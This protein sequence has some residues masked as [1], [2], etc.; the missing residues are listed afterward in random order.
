MM[1]NIIRGL[2]VAKTLALLF[3]LFA[4]DLYASDTEVT[5][6]SNYLE[7]QEEDKY[8]VAKG[9][10]VV[11]WEGKTLKAQ[12]VEMDAGK[13]YMIAKGSACLDDGGSVLQGEVIAYDLKKKIGDISKVHGAA[14]EWFFS[15]MEAKKINDKQFEVYHPR[16]TTCNLERPHYTI[17]ATS[18]KVTLNKNILLYNPVLYFRKVPVLYFPI[19][20]IGLGPH[21]HDIKLSRVITALMG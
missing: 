5:I 2:I 18:A 8:L 17:K 12:S 6:T 14:S 10:V 21:K 11:S 4:P 19:L 20:P 9:S 7:Y 3:I 13:N 16:F 1:K 15:A